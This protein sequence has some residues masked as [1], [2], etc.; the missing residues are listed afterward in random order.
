MATVRV[1]CYKQHEIQVTARIRARE[2]YFTATYDV[3]AV[4]GS[5]LFQQGLIV[6]AFATAEEAEGAAFKT[7]MEWIDGQGLE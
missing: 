6:G 3:R 5:R 4:N 1:V 7:A 2:R